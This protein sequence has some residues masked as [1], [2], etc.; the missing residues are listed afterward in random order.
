MSMMPFRKFDTYA[1]LDTQEVFRVSAEETVTAAEP[2]ADLATLA[3]NHPPNRK[4]NST[5]ETIT[6][7]G[8]STL[9][10]P[11]N[12]ANAG[13]GQTTTAKINAAIPADPP[14]KNTRS[15]PT[16]AKTAK[17]ANPILTDVQDAEE[18]H[19]A[20]IEYDGKIPRT[21]A[22][23]FA[24]LHPNRP[25]A[26]VPLK[27]W[28]VFI[29]DVGRFLDGGFA[30]KAAELGWGPLDLFGADRDR[31][32]AWIDQ[33]GLLWLVA[34]NRLV[35]LSHDAAII[36]I[37]TGARQTYRR[38]PNQLGK[39]LAWELVR[40]SD[41]RSTRRARNFRSRACRAVPHVRSR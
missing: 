10:K 24:R 39:V 37:W 20:I 19:A 25:P 30:K 8:R 9:A 7:E 31:P 14:S 12:S 15:D 11:A 13:A 41:A 5:G 23:G 36:E 38:K 26:D 28:Q 6:W 35:E 22:E 27:R 29:D 2:L 40:D 21:W 33:Q 32:F 17:A 3:A 34:G 18:E 4:R 1:F 16:L